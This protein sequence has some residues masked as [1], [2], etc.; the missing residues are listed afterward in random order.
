MSDL[1]STSIPYGYCHCGCGRK[2]GVPKG[3]SYA[4][5]RYKGVPV[6]YVHGHNGR[7]TGPMYLERDRGHDTL[8]WIWQHNFD[9]FG[10]GKFQFD[11]KTI[12]AHRHFYE[13]R[14]GSL[15]KNIHLHHL[16]E[17]PDCMNPD[18][19]QPLTPAAHAHIRK[20]TKLDF[21]KVEKMKKLYADGG[22]S[23]RTL[24]LEFGVA[25]M[26]AYN[27]VNGKTWAN[28]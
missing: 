25:T 16:C 11:R 18:H 14:H 6:H 3:N 15:P 1:N 5:G 21:E 8:C 13:K 9:T 4:Q 17:Q 19:L 23:Y 10:Y 7:C 28:C 27:A 20:T 12:L 2:T 24:G 26:S 22:Y